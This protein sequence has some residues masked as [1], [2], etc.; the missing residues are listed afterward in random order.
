M[1]IS[2][3]NN[4]ACCIYCNNTLHYTTSYT[5]T[6]HQYNCDDCKIYMLDNHMAEIYSICFYG[7]DEYT[8]ILNYKESFSS[9]K[10]G[11]F[12]SILI[13]DKIIDINPS[14]AKEVIDKYL[15]LI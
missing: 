2:I 6:Y 12:K 8:I 5:I 9:L 3:I 11:D 13:I 7:R 4:K 15:L 14:N 10:D 1:K